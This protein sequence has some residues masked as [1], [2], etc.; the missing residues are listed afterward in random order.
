MAAWRFDLHRAEH[1]LYL[2]Y[3]GSVLAPGETEPIHCFLLL[4]KDSLTVELKSLS[5]II[6]EEIM[7]AW[8]SHLGPPA[9][10]PIT[11]SRTGEIEEP[12]GEM[13]LTAT[14]RFPPEEQGRLR[15]R[16]EGLM[17]KRLDHEPP[18]RL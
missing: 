3:E 4:G 8:I 7:R 10:G 6:P 14:W 13:I 11:H 16:V 18:S 5:R 2:S 17:E 1:P 15:T 12:F 9:Y